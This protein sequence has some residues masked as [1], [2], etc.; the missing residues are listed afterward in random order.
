MTGPVSRAIT[1][2][3]TAELSPLRLDVVDQ[4]EAHKGHAGHSGRGETHFRIEIVSAVFEGLTRVARERRVHDVLKQELADHVHALSVS[5][6]TPA[7]AHLTDQPGG[8]GQDVWGYRHALA[9]KR[10]AE[11]KR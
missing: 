10:K 4:S 11:K 9:E 3:L 2:K 8:S 5:A 7:E 1:E 6:R